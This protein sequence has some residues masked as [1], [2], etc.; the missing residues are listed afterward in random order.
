[1]TGPAPV[2]WP[3]KVENQ[4]LQSAIT[5]L[6]DVCAGD[7]MPIVQ[8]GHPVLR[9]VAAPYQGQLGA[10]LPRLIDAMVTTMRAAPGV[11]LAA[12]QIGIGLAI[13][14]IEDPGL[15]VDAQEAAD[16]RERHPLALQVL[17]N[18]SYTAVGADRRSFY[19][20]CLSVAGLQGVVSRPRQVQLRA[21]NTTGA[22]YEQTYTGWPAR[23][24]QHE[25]DH[26]AGEL[27]LD[28]VKTR[29]IASNENYGRFWAHESTP[30]EAARALGFEGEE[31]WKQY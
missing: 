19:E 21:Q 25:T 13:A 7:P 2:Q 20:G 18:P 12:P 17:I 4:E 23:I 30:L 14:V 6:L 8:T 3:A 22:W 15:G 11:G 10:Q 1:M 5:D 9:T 26:L 28:H 27:Y 16:D 31:C 29:S 24:V